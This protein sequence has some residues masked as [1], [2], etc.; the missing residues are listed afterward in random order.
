MIKT[1]LCV[2]C[3]RTKKI[4]LFTQDRRS[5][6][7]HYS[8]CRACKKK[9]R[10]ERSMKYAAGTHKYN[11]KWRR[12]PKGRHTLGRNMARRKGVSWDLTLEVYSELTQ[13]NCHYCGGNLPEAGIGL[14]QVV[15][16]IGYFLT[17]VVP[18]CIICNRVKGSHFSYAQMIEL[19]PFL[20]KFRKQEEKKNESESTEKTE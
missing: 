8:Y 17:N 3:G 12:S 16:N 6:D 10:Q 19:K 14:D 11:T 7:G 18:C 1:K 5:K 4:T 9:Y 20:I 13:E 2:R 15:P